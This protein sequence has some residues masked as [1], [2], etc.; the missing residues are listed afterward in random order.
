MESLLTAIH[1]YLA[2]S[3]AIT[4]TYA[5]FIGGMIGTSVVFSMEISMKILLRF[6]IFVIKGT[7]LI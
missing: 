5:P 7:H 6:T 4:T 3:A 2:I 1:C